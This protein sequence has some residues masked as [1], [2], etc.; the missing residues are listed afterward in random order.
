MSQIYSETQ[1]YVHQGGDIFLDDN[2]NKVKLSPKYVKTLLKSADGF[3]TEE[4]VTA[5]RLAEIF[6]ENPRS[7][8]T[9]CF[10]TKAK[11]KTKKDYDAEVKDRTDAIVNAKLG[12]VEG[13]VLDLINNPVTR[14]IPGKE[15]V[16]KGRHHGSVDVNG[17]VSFVDMEKA[18][19]PAK[20]YDTRTTLV[21]PRTIKYIIV[22]DVKYSL[23]K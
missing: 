14:E 16:M 23:K 1:F 8:M 17:R 2:G 7:A 21:D 15:R 12:D 22:D 19:D 4:K 18:D 10:T 9:V 20:D 6:R 5:T 13:L 11:N 3:T